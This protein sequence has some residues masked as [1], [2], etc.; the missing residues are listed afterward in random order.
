MSVGSSN[1]T[2]QLNYAIFSPVGKEASKQAERLS[3]GSEEGG[4]IALGVIAN[5]ESESLHTRA[6]RENSTDFDDLQAQIDAL[7]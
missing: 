2:A 5:T 7:R 1:L 4:G 6:A 3:Q